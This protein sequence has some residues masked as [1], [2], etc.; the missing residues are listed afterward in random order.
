MKRKTPTASKKVM[1]YK[2][3]PQILSGKRMQTRIEYLAQLIE[4]THSL[5]P[6]NGKK[7][8]L[9]IFANSVFQQAFKTLLSGS[10]GSMASALMMFD[11]L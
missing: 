11:T 4:K 10:I 6:Y 7:L 8:L 9:K 3:V 2:T 5:N 1:D